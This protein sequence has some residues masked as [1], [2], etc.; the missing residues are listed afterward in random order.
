MLEPRE[1]VQAVGE[2]REVLV[3]DRVV[4]ARQRLRNLCETH[5]RR[6]SL[7][8]RSLLL[9][10]DDSRVGGHSLTR[11]GVPPPLEKDGKLCH[12]PL[13]GFGATAVVTQRM[14]IDWIS[15]AGSKAKACSIALPP[16]TPRS[17]KL[18]LT[19]A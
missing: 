2:L 3:F 14:H 6:F 13:F 7:Q 8:P 17:P 5:V 4:T 10:G 19:L 1:R 15:T 11:E 18:G 9:Q 12:Q 16:L